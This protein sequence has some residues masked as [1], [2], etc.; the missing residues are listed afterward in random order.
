MAL[1]DNQI[2]QGLDPSP[3]MNL[4]EDIKDANILVGGSDYSGPL[5][6]L[7]GVDLIKLLTSLKWQDRF[8]GLKEVTDGI[9]QY[10][11]QEKFS[12][13]INHLLQLSFDEK[14]T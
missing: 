14:N 9:S 1:Y 11:S 7:F 4:I 10:I 2:K 6:N 12:E 5:N 3:N 13:T 8:Q